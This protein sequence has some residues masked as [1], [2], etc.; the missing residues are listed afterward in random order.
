MAIVPFLPTLITTLTK[1]TFYRYLN[2]CSILSSS[3]HTPTLH[4]HVYSTNTPIST[5]YNLFKF[6]FLLS[7]QSASFTTTLLLLFRTSIYSNFYPSLNKPT[8]TTTTPHS[9]SQASHCRNLLL[10]RSSNR[11]FF[12][13][14]CL[15]IS[16]QL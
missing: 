8:T 16:Q 4:I 14:Q 7:L 13:V 1:Q 12:V 6:F 9:I 11:F 5:F 15:H 2:S 3:H 10:F